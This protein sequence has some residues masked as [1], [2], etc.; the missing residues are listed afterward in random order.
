MQQTVPQDFLSLSVQER[1]LLV[2]DLW[3][4]IAIEQ[5]SVPI[6]EPQK[7]ELDNRIKVYND[8]PSEGSD[9]KAVKNRILQRYNEL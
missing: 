3:D 8:N 4:S 5:N 6:T 9:W 1:I 2:E 7:K